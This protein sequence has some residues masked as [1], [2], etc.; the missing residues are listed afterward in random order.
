[1]FCPACGVTYNPRQRSN[2][3]KLGTLGSEGR[4]TATS[5]LSLATLRNLRQLTS[6]PPS[7]RKLLSFT[8]NR[9]DAALQAG[10]FNDFVSLGLVRSGLYRALATSPN[11][12]DH[13]RLTQAVFDALD[14]PMRLYAAN[15]EVLYGQ[16]ERTQ[17]ALRRVLGFH[18][19][20][21]LARGWR[22]TS[23]NLEQCALLSVEYRDLDRLCGNDVA[24]AKCQPVLQSAT[25][26]LRL[27]LC[28][29]L[30]NYL[31][32]ELAIFV[33]YL[34]P[35]AQEQIRL[36]ANQ[37]LIDPW[38]L[39]DADQ[40]TQSFVA[41]LGT[42]GRKSRGKPF[43]GGRFVFVSPRGGFGQ[44]LRRRDVLG[45]DHKIS[46]DDT[47]VLIEEIVA[48]LTK[49]GVLREVEVG[50]R[51]GKAVGYQISA[52]SMIWKVGDAQRAA[53]DPIRVP[54]APEAGLRPNEF[55]RNF[56]R[57]DARDL[58]FFQAH[59]HTAQ[60]RADIR[61]KREEQFRTAELPLLFCS[62]TMELGVDIAELNV[63]NMRNVPP[64]P[65]NY[66]QRSGRAGRSGQP[67]FVFT[68]CTAHSPHDH[69]F[70]R[71]P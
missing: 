30:L 57:G 31:R 68:Y 37:L 60:V 59:E 32:R 7:A 35:T 46:L 15:P 23:P 44:Y 34:D 38:Q 51:G 16:R 18:L 55:F 13:D 1:L 58:A 6:L 14:L 43:V 20:R 65:A 12:I 64:T 42:G 24:W 4:S 26:E 48:A 10:H 70:F 54:Q 40:L 21:D 53:H 41:I 67:A 9:Q 36:D 39:A 28:T 11:G 62:P 56:Y 3:G 33:E 19:Y 61:E 66:A 27:A 25:A 69:Y 29:T 17:S 45:G 47:Q 71:N 63:V 52:A 8:D 22:L 50:R 5:I 49:L 2:F